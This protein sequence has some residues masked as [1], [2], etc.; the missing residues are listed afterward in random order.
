VLVT[1]GERGIRTLEELLVPTPLAGVRLRPLGHLS[2]SKKRAGY[3]RLARSL[4]IAGG[5][6]IL[7]GVGKPK[8]KPGADLN[9]I[10]GTRG[11]LRETAA[12]AGRGARTSEA[13]ATQAICCARAVIA[14]WWHESRET[15]AE[16]NSADDSGSPLAGSP[17]GS[18]CCSRLMRS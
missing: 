8:G 12:G 4:G 2:A 15:Q 13:P 16:T 5:A 18:P 3:Q 1:G 6:M 14:R 7:K 17:C 10:E 11:K 9:D